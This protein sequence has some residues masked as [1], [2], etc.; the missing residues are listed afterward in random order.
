MYPLMQGYD[1]VALNCD[2]EFG[3][4]DQT[5]NLLAGRKIMEAF[6]LKPQSAVVMRLLTGS[7]GRAMGKSLKNFIPIMDNPFGM[8]GKVMS[9]IDEVLW[10]YFELV[11]RVAMSEIEEMKQAVKDGENPM[12]FKKRLARE[13]VTFYHSPKDAENAEK[14]FEETVQRGEMSEELIQ[15]TDIKGKMTII[16]F[17]K[18]VKNGTEV[19]SG[20]MKRII[21]QGGVEV[22]GQKVTN[23]SESIAFETGTVVK[24]GKRD[25][26]K[27][28]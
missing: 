16:E 13:I 20:E 23:I 22:N 19:S 2:V 6:K 5:F 26:I 14:T 24:F 10:E 28:N 15:K 25:F 11:T 9:I 8:Y 4:T 21:E 1:S 17:L 18:Q 7:D 27:V 12:K 3:G